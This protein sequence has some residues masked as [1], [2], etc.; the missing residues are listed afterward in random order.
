VM[1]K[2]FLTDQP[3]VSLQGHLATAKEGKFTDL[4]TKTLFFDIYKFPWDLQ[5]TAFHYFSAVDMLSGSS[6]KNEFLEAFDEDGDG[7]VTYE[8][9]GKKGY[10]D[11]FLNSGGDSVSEFGRTPLGYL[12]GAFIQRTKF[13]KTAQPLWNLQG[14]HIYKEVLYGAA[15][16]TAYK[17]SAMGIESPDPYV[18]NLVWGNGKWPSF[19][20]AWDVYLGVNLYGPQFPFKMSFPSLYGFAF[21]YADLTQKNGEYAGRSRIQPDPEA[22][23]KYASGIKSGATTPLNFIFYLPSGYENVGGIKVPNVEA[24]ADPA[25]VFTATF[26]DGKEIW[27]G[28]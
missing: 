22:L 20:L 24:T 8:D 7:I 26:A 27:K 5:R 14:H 15:C 28:L 13:L 2:D 21:R 11:F 3:L 10:L 16:F 23:T 9:F 18:P 25:Q 6:L 1:G 19:K 17:M 4:V 12:R